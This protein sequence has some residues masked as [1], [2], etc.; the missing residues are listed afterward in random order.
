MLA[1]V[2]SAPTPS[3]YTRSSAPSSSYGLVIPGPPAGLLG[4]V[5]NCSSRRSRAWSPACSCRSSSP[6]AACA[7]TSRR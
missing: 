1:G 7:P 2:C 5:L 6:S 3:A 4:V